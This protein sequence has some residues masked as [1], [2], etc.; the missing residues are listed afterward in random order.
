MAVQMAS[1]SKAVQQRVDELLAVSDKWAKG[2]CKQ[3][4]QQYNVFASSSTPGVFYRTR[5]DGRPGG[6]TCPAARKS[7]SGNCCHLLAVRTV[8]ER[9]QEQAARKPLKTYEELFGNSEAF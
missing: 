9:V 6:C 1:Y 2:V 3:T 5:F 7:R 4:G 8:T